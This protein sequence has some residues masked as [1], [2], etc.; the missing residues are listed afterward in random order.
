MTSYQNSS[1]RGSFEV[2]LHGERKLKCDGS[3]L[4]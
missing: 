1:Q 2:L 3:L 4:T